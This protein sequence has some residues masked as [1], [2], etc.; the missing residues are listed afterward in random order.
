M[1]HL[2]RRQFLKGAGGIAIAT[3]AVGAVA[4]PP[5]VVVGAGLAKTNGQA[6]RL[7]EQGGIRLDG[8]PV[9][10]VESSV[11]LER[12]RLLQAGKRRFVRVVPERV[13]LA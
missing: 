13:T 5:V 9:T 2:T 8:E 10:D 11:S 7:I 6:R 3:S 12:P 4:D 1:Q